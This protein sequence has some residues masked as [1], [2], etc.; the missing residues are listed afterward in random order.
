MKMFS[1]AKLA[2]AAVW[3]V[4]LVGATGVGAYGYKHRDRIRSMLRSV[5][6]DPIVTTNLHLLKSEKIAIPGGGRDGGIAALGD[7]ILMVNNE[8]AAWFV[9]ATKTLKPL[10]IKVPINTA[11]FKADPFNRNTLYQEL[12]G[13]K[14]IA[15]QPIATGVRLLASYAYWNVKDQCTTMRVSALETT[16][17]KLIAGQADA[18]T[19]QTIF[20][21]TPCRP[22]EK[23][24]DN[25][26]RLGL[27][28]GGR[29]A[30]APDG[31]IILTVGGFD[32][33]NEL[34]IEAPQ[35]P[36][37]SYGKTIW[38][39]PV[40]RESRIFT[41][42]HRNP[43]GL[44][45]TSNGQFWLT[46]HA[47]RGGDELN[48]LGA[49][50]NYGY[51]RVHY[52]TQYEMME[53]PLSKRQG[54]HDG[55]EQPMY[56]WVPSI[57]VSSII[58]LEKGGFEHWQGDLI[59]SS[60]AA[61]SLFRVRIEENRVI[62]VE[63]IAVGHRIRDVVEANN[64]AIVMKTDDDF[65]VFMSALGAGT[66]STPVERGAMIG[67]TCQACHST[68][69]DGGDK[70]GPPLWNIVGRDVAAQKSF[71]Y[72]PALRSL[73]GRWSPER[74]Q[75]FIADPAKVAPGTN[76]QLTTKYSEQQLADL[77]A[78]LQTLQ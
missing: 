7:G 57:G 71:N 27:G 72:S 75:A 68:T 22:L 49:G 47:A 29:I 45:V 10:A 25:K 78:Y 16:Q 35:K 69:P 26:Q 30:P 40:T 50:K 36:D 51:P 65:L 21:T 31:S 38:I 73:G 62:F 8:G 34:V 37:N 56:A 53:W 28:Y 52:G 55:Y 24:P 63:P 61:Q 41:M 20:E 67:A 12:F 5:N 43:Q 2:L 9:D 54:R 77:I 60:L 19:W 14:D 3:L 17:A 58:S 44:T 13:V 23:Q 18:G 33:E 15:I 4:S 48:L 39:N 1:A 32:P 6:N 76:M 74:L 46:E 66:A 59:V 64:G 70:I 42:G 11:E